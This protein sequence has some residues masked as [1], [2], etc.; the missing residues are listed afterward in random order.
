MSITLYKG[1]KS[2]GN[3]VTYTTSQANLQ[4]DGIFTTADVNAGNWIFYQGKNYHGPSV[5]KQR[6]VESDVSIS[7]VNG[8]VFLVEE[9]LILFKD[10][11]F[12]GD[13]KVLRI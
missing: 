3:G 12:R 7:Q 6:R 8:S 1:E 9:G 4:Q 2:Q 13:R 10:T 11:D 5:K